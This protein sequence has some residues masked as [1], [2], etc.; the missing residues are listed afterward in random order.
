MKAKIFRAKSDLFFDAE[1]TTG[2]LEIGGLLDQLDG[3]R[4]F[5][6][7]LL[8]NRDA[9]Q[10]AMTF[11]I[12]GQKIRISARHDLR[13]SAF[14]AAVIAKNRHHAGLRIMENKA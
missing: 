7:R 8:S 10:S 5:D 1:G 6:Q 13:Q 2:K 14:P 3:L 12:A 9:K 4:P 11:D